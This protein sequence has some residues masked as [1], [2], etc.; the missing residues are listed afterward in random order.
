MKNTKLLICFN[1]KR[2]YLQG[3]NFYNIITAMLSKSYKIKFYEVDCQN[4]LKETVLLNFMQD[5]AA[6]DA[7]NLGFGYSA[8]K[9]GNIGWFL[10]KYHIKLYKPL[11]NDGCIKIQSESKGLLKINFIRDFDIFNNNDEKIGEA[12]SSWILANLSTGGVLKAEDVFPNQFEPVDRNILRSTF[13]KIPTPAVNTCTKE[14]TA[15]YY[16]TDINSH[17]NNAIYIGWAN[18]ALPFDILQNTRIEELEIQY[19]QQVKYGEKVIVCAEE[20]SPYNYLISLNKED[21]T[22]VCLIREKRI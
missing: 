12:T 8:I 11:V 4:R 19:K 6:E 21:G 16:D 3:Y 7:E 1:L 13:P 20:T 5:I 18:E 22:T 10:T 14:F 15:S 2:V 17:V 9:S